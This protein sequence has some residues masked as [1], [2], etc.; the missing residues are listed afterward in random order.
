MLF[1]EKGGY[2]V[3]LSAVQMGA[4]IISTHASVRVVRYTKK[5]VIL[6]TIA[7]LYSDYSV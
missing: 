3:K 5:L 4:D 7:R 2:F 1:T 6:E